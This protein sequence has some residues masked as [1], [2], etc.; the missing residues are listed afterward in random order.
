MHARLV[1]LVLVV[2]LAL[3]APA[4]APAA[5]APRPAI[6]LSGPAAVAPGGSVGV[7]LTGLAAERSYRLTAIVP[8]ARAVALPL[9][10]DGRARGAFGGDDE[11]KARGR[12]RYEGQLVQLVQALAPAGAASVKATLR[13]STATGRRVATTP[14]RLRVQRATIDPPTSPDGNGVATTLHGLVVGGR[15][16]LHVVVDAP[17][18]CAPQSAGD[19]LAVG[20]TDQRVDL[21]DLARDLGR[22]CSL[23]SRTAVIGH[24]ELRTTITGTSLVLATSAPFDVVVP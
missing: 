22:V 6:S 2:L 15:Y 8:G 5:R 13:L 1:V 3:A 11:G 20:S 7:A 9:V 24:L 23:P 12:L 17:G 14:W 18:G 10:R 16:G 4:V 19:P 21:V